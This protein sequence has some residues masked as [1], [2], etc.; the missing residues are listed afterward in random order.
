VGDAVQ[1]LTEHTE[2]MR[3]LASK[4]DA[5]IL[6]AIESGAT[7]VRVAAAAGLSRQQVHNIIRENTK[8]PVT[9]VLNE[10]EEKGT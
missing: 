3:E 8:S 6:A 10:V 9:F 5:L 1:A 4:R 7:V 2:A